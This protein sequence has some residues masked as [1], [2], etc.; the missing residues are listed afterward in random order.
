M[1]QYFVTLSLFQIIVTMVALETFNREEIEALKE[2]IENYKWHVTNIDKSEAYNIGRRKCYVK[3]ILFLFILNPLIVLPGIVILHIRPYWIIFPC[4]D[5]NTHAVLTTIYLLFV[6]SSCGVVYSH[7]L[8]HVYFSMCVKIQ[9]ELLTDYFRKQ[10]T[11]IGRS[12]IFSEKCITQQ[13]V[14]N[15]LVNGIIRHSDLLG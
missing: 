3:I 6:I 9:M 1:D 13:D 15:W 2:E 10:C 8:L 4:D 11:L 7:V 12:D 5:W 14:H